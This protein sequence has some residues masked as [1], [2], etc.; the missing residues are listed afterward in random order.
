MTEVVAKVSTPR[1][2]H[3]KAIVEL[4]GGD[5][6]LAVY[7]PKTETLTVPGIE[8]DVLE[9]AR[10]SVEQGTAAPT[11]SMRTRKVAELRRACEAAITGGFPSS[12][13][14]ALS[15]YDSE[16][17]D[18]LNLIGAVSSEADMWYAC[19]PS[20]RQPKEYVF[21]THAQLLQVL[22]DGKDVKQAALQQF[23]T[24]RTEAEEALTLDVL[25]S[26]V[27]E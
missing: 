26:I 16:M 18:Q 4:A 11:L 20:Q 5:F 2:R 19:R 22:S 1:G 24:K 9:A 12:A 3:L 27:W 17:E 6:S 14:G 10:N 7:E 8:Q 25:N 21:H 23:N 15:W 13:L